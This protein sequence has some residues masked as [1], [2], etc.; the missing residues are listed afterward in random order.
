MAEFTNEDFYYQSILD[1]AS[2]FQKLPKYFKNGSFHPAWQAELAF[3]QH[4]IWASIT[5]KK[6]ISENLYY[7]YIG[8]A[9]T[10]NIQVVYFPI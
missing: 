6:Q 10:N 8:K 4:K 7:Y 1:L 3:E 9:S 2:E 5:K